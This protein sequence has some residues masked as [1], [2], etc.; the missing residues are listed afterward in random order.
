MAIIR[1][2]RSEKCFEVAEAQS[3]ST[4]P[5]DQALAQI[6]QIVGMVNRRMEDSTSKDIQETASRNLEAY[7]SS[8]E[9][10]EEGSDA[11]PIRPKMVLEA[12]TASGSGSSSDGNGPRLLTDGEESS[13]RGG[14][15]S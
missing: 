2:R 8:I 14:S 15:A 3:K 1:K 13:D 6:N 12:S 11:E 5:L 10:I 9:G 4:D 7:L